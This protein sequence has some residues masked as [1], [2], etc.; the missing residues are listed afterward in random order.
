MVDAGRR[1]VPVAGL[2]SGIPGQHA[3][4][5]VQD[6]AAAVAIDDCDLDALLVAEGG[7]GHTADA[8]KRQLEAHD[9]ERSPRLVAHE[10]RVRDDQLARVGRAVGLGN[11]HLA[12]LR[13]ERRAEEGVVAHVVRER[14]CRCGTAAHDASPLA[15]VEVD[16]R[17]RADSAGIGALERA[18]RAVDLEQIARRLPS[19]CRRGTPCHPRA[20]GVRVASGRTRRRWSWPL[21]RPAGQGAGRGGH[22]SWRARRRPARSRRVRAGGS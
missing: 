6:R 11:V 13:R 5:R 16:R 14:L 20:G 22:S 7:R 1:Q 10:R 8:R 9:A 17:G 3:A 21:R 19:E 15:A 12:W 2:R 18:E 4:G